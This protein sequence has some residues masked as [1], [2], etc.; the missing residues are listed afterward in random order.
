MKLVA[1]S[2]KK[3]EEQNIG[4]YRAGN[5]ISYFANEIRRSSKFA[6]CFY[7]LRFSY[8]FESTNDKVYFAYNYPYT[9]SQLTEYLY[10]LETNSKTSEYL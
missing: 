6:K 1:Y 9:Y 8:T 10:R 2:I 7:T 3:N 4:W 5:D